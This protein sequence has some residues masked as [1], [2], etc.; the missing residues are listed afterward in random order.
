VGDADDWE[1]FNLTRT[2]IVQW[3]VC[4]TT[5][6]K[7]EVGKKDLNKIPLTLW[8]NSKMLRGKG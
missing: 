4:A 6:E 1:K 8:E 3:L 2:E 7:K 5:E